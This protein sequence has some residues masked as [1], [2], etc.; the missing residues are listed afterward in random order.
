MLFQQAI[1]LSGCAFGLLSDARESHKDIEMRNEFLTSFY[2]SFSMVYITSR[3]KI[4]LHVWD[5][6][7]NARLRRWG[8]WGLFCVV[9]SLCG[10]I[11]LRS[12]FWC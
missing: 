12:R 4:F 8:F 11:A 10:H 9:P 6:L 5:G 3:A 7:R 2:F 1:W